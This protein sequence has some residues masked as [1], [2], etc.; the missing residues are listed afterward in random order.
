MAKSREQYIAENSD[1]YDADLIT[2]SLI[3]EKTVRRLVKDGDIELPYKDLDKIKDKRWNTKQMSSRLLRGI[4]N[5]DPVKKIAVSLV[6]I[7]NNNKAAAM[8]NARTMVTSAEN[9]GRLDSYNE[10]DSLGVVQKKK[11]IATPDDRTRKSH[12][13][14]DGEEVD[15]NDKFS[16][17]LDY[18]GDPSGDPAEV[19]NCRCTMVDRIVGFRRADGTISKVEREK[20]DTIHDRQMKE[21]KKRREN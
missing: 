11:W 12:L 13:E 21:E 6:D 15:I 8:R 17:K 4:L 3:D 16:N 7:T 1:D 18:P 20:D 14:I 10:L 5:G 19:Y 2:F 9:R